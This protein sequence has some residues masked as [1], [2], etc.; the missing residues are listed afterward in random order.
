MKVLV[1]HNSYLQTGGEDVV[2]EQE[3]RLLSH[4]GDEVIEFHSR[5]RPISHGIRQKI[6]IA[7]NALWSSSAARS[8][9]E[10]IARERPEVAHFHN[11]FSAISPSC[12][13]ACRGLGVPVVQTVHNY[14]IM[15]PSSDFFRAGKVCESCLGKPVPWPAI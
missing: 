14:R 12:Y 5:N 15:C 3:K 7:R 11:V 2:F 4:Y 6:A 13:Y 10:L 9:V 8:I 1:V